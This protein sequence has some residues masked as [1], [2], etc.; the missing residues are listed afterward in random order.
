[1]SLIGSILHA[2]FLKEGRDLFRIRLDPIHVIAYLLFKFLLV[3][4]GLALSHAD[5][6]VAV[7]KFVGV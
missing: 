5:F 1:M 6:Q 2:L 4:G 7:D 3:G